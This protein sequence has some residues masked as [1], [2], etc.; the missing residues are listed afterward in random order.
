M[1][2]WLRYFLAVGVVAVIL[3]SALWFLEQV[4]HRAGLMFSSYPS[5]TGGRT[6]PRQVWP[7][8]MFNAVLAMAL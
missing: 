2:L 1:K 5:G 6:C 8:D 7:M 4:L 3:V